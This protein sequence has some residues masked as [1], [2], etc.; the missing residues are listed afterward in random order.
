MTL[1]RIR[2]DLHIHT[3]L[4]PCGELEMTPT[5]IVLTSCEKGL[6]VIAICDHNTAENVIGVQRAAKRS[7]LTV[8]A[9][10]EVATAEEVH[11]LGIFDTAEQALTL[12]GKIYGHLLPGKNDEDLF[13]IQV[14]ANEFDEVDGIE[15]RMLI[16]G[17]T[18]PLEDVIDAIHA[19]GGLAIPSH[20][21]RESY[22]L[23]GQLGI[24][25]DDLNADALEISARGDVNV[26]RAIPG[27]DRFSFITSSDAHRLNEIGQAYTDFYIEEVNINEMKKAL[28]QEE[29]RKTSIGKAA[30]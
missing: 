16:G 3:C 19:F 29:E 5:S 14:I 27:T 10:M 4:S 12:Q 21:D 30:C 15:E 7:D 18:L 9:G 1:R 22:S 23:I 6:D 26:M 28:N 8:M 13:G 25:P 20:I 11:I 17:T 24:V 2:A